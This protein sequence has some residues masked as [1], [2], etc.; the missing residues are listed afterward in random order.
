MLCVLVISG[1][2]LNWYL[3]FRFEHDHTVRQFITKSL[4]KVK[5]TMCIIHVQKH[6]LEC[7][8]YI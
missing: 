8:H 5:D 1:V 6:V 7:D 2:A 3:A 4:S